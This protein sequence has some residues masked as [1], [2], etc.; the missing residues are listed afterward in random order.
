MDITWLFWLV[1]KL[2]GLLLFGIIALYIG[3][4]I[5][6]Y[7]NLMFFHKQGAKCIYVPIVGHPILFMKKKGPGDQLSKWCQILEENKDKPLIATNTTKTT[8]SSIFLLDENL[9]KELLVKEF[10]CCHKVQ[11]F[12]HCNLGFFFENGQKM[13]EARA[14][15]RSGMS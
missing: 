8:M 5:I 9:I 1:A 14:C 4:E 13:L 7:K 10:D 15:G 12:N 6:V 3:R 2:F 11:F